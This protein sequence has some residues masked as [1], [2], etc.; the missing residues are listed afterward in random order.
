MSMRLDINEFD[1]MTLSQVVRD[2]ERQYLCWAINKANGNKA[3]AASL[4]GMTY[5]TFTRKFANL[6]LKV[7]Y[8]AD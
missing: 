1:G 5:Q 2:A 8:H 6:D 3:R 4:A 7:T